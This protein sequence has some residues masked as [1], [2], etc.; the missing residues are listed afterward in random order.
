MTT[1]ARARRRVCRA[2]ARAPERRR[3]RLCSPQG[4]AARGRIADEIIMPSERIQVGN[5]YYLLASS[6]APRRPRQ[7]L[8]HAES[9]AI[10]D[11]AG[12]IPL[13]GL[14]PFGLLHRGTRFLDRFE[15]RVN[16]NLPILLSSVQ[17]DDGCE[18]VTHLTNSDEAQN[19]EIILERDT[20]AIERRKTLVDQT[21][22]ETLHLLHYG[23]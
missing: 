13:T 21:L 15:L 23:P 5:D 3:R 4:G 16:G 2:S 11:L 1:C 18:L 19:G 12:D 6:L 8:S 9:F 7:L 14:D 10:F 20:V 22:Y 17:S